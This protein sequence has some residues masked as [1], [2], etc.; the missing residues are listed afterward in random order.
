MSREYKRNW[1]I[2]ETINHLYEASRRISIFA[3]SSSILRDIGE[4]LE[5][6]QVIQREE[7]FSEEIEPLIDA[8]NEALQLHKQRLEIYQ[9]Q[10][11]CESGLSS[12]PEGLTPKP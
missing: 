5:P 12:T 11:A 2:E 10:Y 1:Y 4:V 3:T 6:L 9:M 8:L 7:A